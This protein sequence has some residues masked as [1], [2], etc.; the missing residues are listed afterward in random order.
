M[1]EQEFGKK[2]EEWGES[3]ERSIEA[4][5]GLLD[6]GLTR[7]WGESRLFRAGVRGIS[8]VAALGL[9][10]GAGRLWKRGHRRAALWCGA[11]GAAG[12][13]EKALWLREKGRRRG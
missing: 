10:A 6:E 3:L 1:T 5:A 12:I 11:L 13:G 8:F 7:A 4:A 2:A 9:L